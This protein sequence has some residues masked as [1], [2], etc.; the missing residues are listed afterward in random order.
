MLNPP[1]QLRPEFQIGLLRVLGRREQDGR[2][3]GLGHDVELG[4]LVRLVVELVQS[5]LSAGGHAALVGSPLLVTGL[6]FRAFVTEHLRRGKY[7]SNI[8]LTKT[9]FFFKVFV[10]PKLLMVLIV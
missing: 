7:N 8:N 3:V 5:P 1:W 2:L 9:I 4:P 6:A 10:E